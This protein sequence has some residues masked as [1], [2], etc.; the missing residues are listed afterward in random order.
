MLLTF[1]DTSF[2]GNTLSVDDYT[3]VIQCVCNDVQV[4]LPIPNIN[5][6]F[7]ATLKVRYK[8]S[9][10]GEP[11]QELKTKRQTQD[12]E[13][14]VAMF[15]VGL[16]FPQVECNDL[17]KVKGVLQSQCQRNNSSNLPQYSIQGT[18]DQGR[19]AVEFEFKVTGNP[20]KNE[21]E[22]KSNAYK[23]LVD[24]VAKCDPKIKRDVKFKELGLLIPDVQCRMSGDVYYAEGSL[25][26][27]FLPKPDKLFPNKKDAEKYAATFAL[28]AVYKIECSDGVSKNTLHQTLE[29]EGGKV[30]QYYPER[31][32]EQK[33]RSSVQIQFK[34]KVTSGENEESAI[35]NWYKAVNDII[36]YSSP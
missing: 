15:A 5:G 21:N 8:F 3:S 29:R 32:G 14:R 18:L 6:Q 11:M 26:Y 9:D 28:A 30:L 34:V 13:K 24:I 22:A 17:D 23:A 20:G 35:Q 25:E 33:F 2:H 36:E 1:D 31:M 10:K 16:A 4:V 27:K 19:K 7:E 12:A